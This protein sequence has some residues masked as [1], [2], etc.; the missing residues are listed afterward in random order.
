MIAHILLSLL[1]GGTLIAICS[2][3]AELLGPTL[4]GL[5]AG[6]PSTLVISMMFVG[7][8]ESP[9]AASHETTFIP[10]A[11]G[12][13]CLLMG[14]F[15]FFASL[16]LAAALG[17]SLLVWMGLAAFAVM[18]PPATLAVTL[19]VQFV[20]LALGFLLTR[21]VV[22]QKPAGSTH[23]SAIQILLRALFGGSIV[24]TSV[25]L[26]HVAGVTVGGVAATFPAIGISTLLIV[27]RSRGITYATALL[28]PIMV[29][30]CVTMLTCILIVRYA[31][32]A[33]GVWTG[34]ALAVAGSILSAWVLYRA[35]KLRPPTPIT[36]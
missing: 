21:H 9:Q 13:N 30:T 12:L 11:L 16:G 5:I 17:I 14:L 32:P 2:I 33:V 23:C 22:R 35:P 3:T 27:S 31:F 24:A 1:I 15:G 19:L 29:S 25:W 6:L 34:A 20:G 10:M 7:L 36:T 18:N 28:R 26:S 4:G 8:T